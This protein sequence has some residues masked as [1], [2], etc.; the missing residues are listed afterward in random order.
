MT[1]TV[2]SPGAP[3]IDVPGVRRREAVGHRP[4]ALLRVVYL[5]PDQI[6]VKLARYPPGN[7]L[8]DQLRVL[9]FPGNAVEA[10]EAHAPEV[11]QQVFKLQRPRVSPGRPPSR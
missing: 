10:G 9:D 8:L 5:S 1:A 3:D 6:V 11:L 7:H 4:A 2:E